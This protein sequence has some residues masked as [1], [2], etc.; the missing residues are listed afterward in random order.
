[1]PSSVNINLPNSH[2]LI[3][4]SNAP[5][6]IRGRVELDLKS[7]K[8]ISSLIVKLKA[9]EELK[10]SHNFLPEKSISLNQSLCVVENKELSKGFHKLVASIISFSVD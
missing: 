2:N 5:K 9:V 4:F 8:F 6:F 3:T 10:F 7:N 1:M